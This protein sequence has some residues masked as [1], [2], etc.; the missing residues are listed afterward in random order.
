MHRRS[1]TVSMTSVD[2]AEGKRHEA[3][4]LRKIGRAEEECFGAAR[5]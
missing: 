2:D 5:S 4:R 1:P 3:Q